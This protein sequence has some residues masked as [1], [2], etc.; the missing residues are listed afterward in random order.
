MLEALQVERILVRPEGI[1]FLEL[2]LLLV[3]AGAQVEHLAM[4]QAQKQGEMAVPGV[5]VDIT[6]VEEVVL[7]VRVT[8]VEVRS[9]QE[10]A[11]EEAAAALEL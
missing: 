9:I 10:T 4:A 1:L 7:L 6:A 5:A 3:A 11:E 8:M 2:S